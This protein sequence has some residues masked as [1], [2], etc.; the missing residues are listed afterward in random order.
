M[1]DPADPNTFKQGMNN[2]DCARAGL[3]S[4]STNDMYLLSFGGISYLQV[5]GGMIVPDEEL[6]FTNSVTTVKIDANGNF[7]Q[8]LEGA[9]QLFRQ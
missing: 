7:S 5:S 2:Y 9:I 1:A 8:Y 6:P 4:K 3:Y